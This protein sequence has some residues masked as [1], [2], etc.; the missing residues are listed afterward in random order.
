[1]KVGGVTNRQS[2]GDRILTV[3]DPLDG[4]DIFL[5]LGEGRVVLQ[6]LELGLALNVVLPP[7]CELLR[8]RPTKNKGS[9][10]MGAR[11]SEVH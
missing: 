4:L 5:V 3:V 8:L 1:V 10:G 9:Y 6:H 11:V 2:N 7:R